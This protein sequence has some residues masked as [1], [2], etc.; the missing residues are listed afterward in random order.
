MVYAVKNLRRS[1]RIADKYSDAFSYCESNN[2]MNDDASY[3]ADRSNVVHLRRSS[4]I[5]D[6][7]SDTFSYCETLSDVDDDTYDV[8]TYDTQNK[9]ALKSS[10]AN[11]VRDY[12]HKQY[13]RS[14]RLAQKKPVCYT[15]GVQ[16]YV[17]DTTTLRRSVRLSNMDEVDYR[18]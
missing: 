7:Y 2:N 17:K 3:I 4:R 15:E 10:I 12:I 8:D 16:P 14:A 13:R 5:A 1:S 11:E 6:K 9:R 18:E